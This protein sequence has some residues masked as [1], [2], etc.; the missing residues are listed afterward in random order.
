MFRIEPTRD[1]AHSELTKR[2][3]ATVTV[4]VKPGHDCSGYGESQDKG[5]CDKRVRHNR[6]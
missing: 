2:A 6:V 3:T 4:K 1:D 5:S